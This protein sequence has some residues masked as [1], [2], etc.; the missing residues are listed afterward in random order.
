VY[1]ARW[2]PHRSTGR[3]RERGTLFIYAAVFR[4]G[5]VPERVSAVDGEFIRQDADGDLDKSSGPKFTRIF[6]SARI[7]TSFAEVYS[8]RVRAP[9]SVSPSTRI[10]RAERRRESSRMSRLVRRNTFVI[11][12]RKRRGR[13]FDS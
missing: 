6:H 5:S 8:S 12:A 1:A 9:H 2:W 11:Y 4:F 3:T 7:N 10:Y 13:R